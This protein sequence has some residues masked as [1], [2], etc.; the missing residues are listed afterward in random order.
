VREIASLDGDVSSMVP[1]QVEKALK[2]K[3]SGMSDRQIPPNAL[4]D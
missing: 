3:L 1:P 2:L 4:R